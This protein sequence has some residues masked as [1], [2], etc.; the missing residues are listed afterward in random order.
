MT[1]AETVTN[2]RA[3]LLAT[4]WAVQRT[5]Q[6]RTRPGEFG[7]GLHSVPDRI[8]I[9]TDSAYVVGCMTDWIEKWCS[10]NFANARGLH[11]ASKYTVRDI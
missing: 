2:Q 3:E 9:K 11:V 1:G 7:A 6:I 4:I 8:V 5:F 10:N